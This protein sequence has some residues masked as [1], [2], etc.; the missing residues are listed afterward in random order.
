VQQEKDMTNRIFDRNTLLSVWELAKGIEYYDPMVI[1]WNLAMTIRHM[2][3]KECEAVR[4][5]WH[6]LVDGD[7]I[8]PPI[9][10]FKDIRLLEP[11]LKK[12]KAK[13]IIQPTPV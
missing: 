8:P 10:N 7:S 6:M 3:K 12:L 1:G 2:T 5:Q 9:K 13:G 4:K 11:I